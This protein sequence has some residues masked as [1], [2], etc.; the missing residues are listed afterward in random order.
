[1][2]IKGFLT[3]M[4][5]TQFYRIKFLSE[6]LIFVKWYQSPPLHAPVLK[7]Y[8]EE[9]TTILN[10]AT[11]PVYII[12][13]LELGRIH[14]VTFLRD[15]AIMLL[16][17]PNYGGSTAFAGDEITKVFVKV[18]R[19]AMHQPRDTDMFNSAKAAF[20]YLEGL[21]P[22]LLEGMDWQQAILEE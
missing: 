19:Q 4:G 17:H 5:I 16:K 21:E 18:F 11:R 9:L 1:M 7:Q 14:D 13:D 6:Q 10:K 20:G 12:S 22:A 8:Q 2:V 15:L 3:F